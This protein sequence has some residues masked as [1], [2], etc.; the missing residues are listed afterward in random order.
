MQAN[1]DEHADLLYIQ[2]ESDDVQDD[3]GWGPFAGSR[4]T[5]MAMA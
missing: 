2:R 4:P 3:N 5:S 1:N